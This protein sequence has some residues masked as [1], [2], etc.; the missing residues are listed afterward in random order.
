MQFETYIPGK[1]NKVNSSGEEH[2]R[3]TLILSTIKQII[4]IETAPEIYI[5]FGARRHDR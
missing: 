3:N 1:C 4:I 5:I 2:E